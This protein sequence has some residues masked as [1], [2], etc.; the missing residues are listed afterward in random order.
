MPQT[1]PARIGNLGLDPV[2]QRH[3]FSPI[4]LSLKTEGLSSIVYPKTT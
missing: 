3:R 1:P 4:Q 2:N